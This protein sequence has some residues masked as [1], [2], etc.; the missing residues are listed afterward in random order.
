LCK[1]KRVWGLGFGTS[2]DKVCCGVFP[3]GARQKRPNASMT[4]EPRIW[5]LFK[6][7]T[8]TPD[9]LGTNM[10]TGGR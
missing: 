7:N 3:L 9:T 2:S 10:R 4:L 8:A 6:K 1:T 5:T